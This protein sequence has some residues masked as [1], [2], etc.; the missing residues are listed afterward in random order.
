MSS[1]VAS[2][3]TRAPHQGRRIAFRAHLA[4]FELLDIYKQQPTRQRL[5]D[6]GGGDGMHARF[7]RHH[8]MSVDIVDVRAG[9]AELSYEG[10][11]LTFTATEAYDFIWAS[12]V[13]EHMPNPGLFFTK[14]Y[15]DLADGGWAAITVPPLKHDMTFSHVTLWN[16][17]LLLIHL[18]RA[19]FDTRDARVATYGYNITVL[20]RKN[21]NRPSGPLKTFLPAVTWN[22]TF[23]EG[24][25]PCL[26]WRAHDLPLD[27]SMAMLPLAQAIELLNKTPPK[28]PHFFCAIEPK[29][30]KMRPFYFDPESQLV[31]SVG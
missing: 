7:F 25:I 19:G 30:T 23:F 16:A 8:G 15:A 13:A 10:D 21:A 11:Y 1:T 20:A 28:Q 2:L 24:R 31:C 3:T 27:E 12:H 5:L 17:G 18:V 22:E 29:S 9:L 4:A 14:L 6:I 26:N